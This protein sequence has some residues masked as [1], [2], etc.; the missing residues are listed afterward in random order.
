MIG[1]F[2]L[3]VFRYDGIT[4]NRK[5]SRVLNRSQIPPRR[6]QAIPR[7][8][9]EATHQI[10]KH[11]IISGFSGWLLAI[12]LD[13][14][15]ESATDLNQWLGKPLKWL[16]MW[17]PDKPFLQ[18][19]EFT[20]LMLLYIGGL[21]LAW[22]VGL[23]IF[24]RQKQQGIIYPKILYEDELAAAVSVLDRP[25]IAD[26]VLREQVEDL[27]YT[28]AETV[29]TAI[30]VPPKYYRAYF[31]AQSSAGPAISGFRIGRQFQLAE[32]KNQS[33]DH[34]LQADTEPID[35]MISRK[36]TVSVMR[37]VQDEFNESDIHQM[38]MV[39]NP[40]KFRMCFIMAVLDPDAVIDEHD[41]TFLQVSYI[42]RSLGFID[43]LVDYVLQYE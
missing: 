43:T 38:V 7:A 34:L 10:K 5:G 37:D 30:G 31:V 9:R 41:E 25:G 21:R 27:M 19:I 12:I 26:E 11:Y 14:Y 16:G 29:A 3:C 18:W 33:I 24:R 8:A 15:G 40:G 23:K 17:Q 4:Y 20:A 2:F 1:D 13:G 32:K 36:K 42:V 6:K 22:K 28:V 35:R 39:R